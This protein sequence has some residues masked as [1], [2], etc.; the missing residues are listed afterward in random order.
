MRIVHLLLTSRFAG[1]ER[2]VLELAA[3][4]S[5]DHDVTVML[6]RAG[7]QDRPDAIAH[8]VDPRVRIEV[9][10]DLL[11]SARARG[12][13]CGGCSPTLHTPTSAAAAARCTDFRANAC[14]WRPCTSNTNRASTHHWT[15]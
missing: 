9:V 5:A 14:A 15:G 12:V 11:A 1:T 7:T 3:A 13:C 6:R 2:H 10:G 4:Q 8:R